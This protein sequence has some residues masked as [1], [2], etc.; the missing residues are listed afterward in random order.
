MRV[1]NVRR[2]RRSRIVHARLSRVSF[3]NFD[4]SDAQGE[5]IKIHEL[6][7]LDNIFQ[8]FYKYYMKYCKMKK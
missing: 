4:L 1:E 6:Q 8:S 2:I 3:Q 7:V 5:G